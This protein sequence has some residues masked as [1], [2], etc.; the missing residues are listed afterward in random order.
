MSFLTS[1]DYLEAAGLGLFT[2]TSIVANDPYFQSLSL[3]NDPATNSPTDDYLDK[4]S[5]F[6]GASSNKIMDLDLFLMFEYKKY[7]PT[8]YLNTFNIINIC[9]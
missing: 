3:P 6:G 8:L 1:L 2:G 9:I 5:I 4:L 7:L